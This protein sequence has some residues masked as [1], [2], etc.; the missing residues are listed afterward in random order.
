MRERPDAVLIAGPTGSGK[1]ALAMRWAARVGGM[2]V[3]ADSMQVYRDLRI[4]TARPTREHERRVPHALFG[5]VDGGVGYSVSRWLDGAAAAARRATDSGLIPIF[6]GG[7]GLYFKVLTQGLSEIPPVPE[8]V[9]EEIR[10]WAAAQTPAELHQVLAERDP[11]TAARLHPTD[12][13][14]LIR[15]LEV[16]RATGCSLLTYQERR[17]TPV[18]DIARCVAICLTPDR[19]ELR[20]TLDQRFDR[21]VEGGAIEE[22]ARLAGR[23]LDPALPVMRAIG[24]PP[25]LRH[26]AGGIDLATAS[27]QVKADTR[28]YVKRQETFARH[29]L[30]GFRRITPDQADATL[31]A[32]LQS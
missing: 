7:T 24:V 6:V 13:Q 19:A 3:N 18:C 21:M 30:H 20:T 22:V 16:H 11:L 28:Q 32:E 5:S 10:A 31:A 9:R 29:Q 25:L 1:S 8:A 26:L 12:P 14:R 17:A 27:A 15:A 2:V 4:V 23:Q